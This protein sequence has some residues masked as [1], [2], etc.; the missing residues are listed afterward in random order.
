[1]SIDE[2][3]AHAKEK[4][5][6][7]KERAKHF[8]TV[9]NKNM[10]LECAEEHDQLAEWLI[11]L[12][13]YQTLEEQDRL[14]K[15]PCKVGDIVWDNDYGRPYAYTITAFSFGECEGYIDE[16][17]ETKEVVFYYTNSNGSVT[18]SFAESE[19]GKSVFLSK[20][21]AK[22]KLKELRGAE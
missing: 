19:I 7:H 16:P 8:D 20:S 10:C 21:E 11:Q 3:I 14:I 9:D 6:E 17:V 15:L 5:Y 2:A 12:K 1:M 18:G 4:A 22:E 13:E